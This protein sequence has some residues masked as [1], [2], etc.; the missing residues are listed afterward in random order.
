MTAESRTNKTKDEVQPAFNAFSFN[1]EW[2][3][4]IGLRRWKGENKLIEYISKITPSF[5]SDPRSKSWRLVP[6][7]ALDHPDHIRRGQGCQFCLR[8]VHLRS[9]RVQHSVPEQA[10]RVRTTCFGLVMKDLDSALNFPW[11]GIGTL[12]TAKPTFRSCMTA[13]SVM[14]AYRSAI[15]WSRGL[16]TSRILRLRSMMRTFKGISYTVQIVLASIWL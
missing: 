1:P 12:S 13:A 6:I 15:G 9:G 4:S 11:S 2:N 3:Q 8:W 14:F 7:R 5:F 16:L 10:L